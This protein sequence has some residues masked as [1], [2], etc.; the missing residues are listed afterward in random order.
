MTAPTDVVDAQ[1]HMGPGG[2]SEVLAA[3]DALGIQAALVDEYWLRAFNNEPHHK[4]ANGGYRPLCP[5]AEIAAQLHPERFAWLLRIHRLDP[6]YRA[7]IRMV[8]DAPA[9]KA[10]RIDPGMSPAEM[11]EWAE[12]GY[13]HVLAAAAECG[14]PVF[15]FAPDRPDAFARAARAFPD[16][17]IA[18][19]H[20]GI[21][22]NGMRGTIGG[23]LPPRDEAGQLA[24]F[25]EICA[26]GEL[27]NIALKWG[28]A[29][30]M[31]ERP[32]WPGDGL[33]PILRRAVDAFG[34]ERVFWASDY[35][36]NQCGES[37]AELL[38]GVR[39]CPLLSDAERVAV[40]GGGLRA[41]L[42]WQAA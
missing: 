35:S 30:G 15:V 21:F 28:H 5:T 12:G 9:G 3:M 14:L 11:R 29:S 16:L 1:I 19:D 4:L 25:D 42:D 17:R 33:W 22:S 38:F 23:G 24:L 36:T 32:A 39:G 34:A 27:P 7:V 40:L 41:W 13:D 10:L 8:R 6:E 20:C 2:I 37:W 31:F 18:I 26:L